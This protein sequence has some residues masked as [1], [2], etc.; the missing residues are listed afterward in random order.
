MI[1]SRAAGSAA[2]LALSIAGAGLLT[3]AV[4]AAEPDAPRDD[5]SRPLPSLEGEELAG[6]ALGR[7]QFRTIRLSGARADGSGGLGPVFNRT[8][9]SGCHVRNGRGRPPAS[10]AAPLTTM[11]IRLGPGS[12][13]GRQLNDKAVSGVEPEGRAVFLPNPVVHVE[14]DGVAWPLPSARVAIRKPAL[15][16]PAPP[17]ELSPRVAPHVAG[18]G[19]LERIPEAALAALVDPHDRDG[20]GISGRRGGDGNGRLG[21]RAELPGVEAQV[22]RALHEDMGVTSSLQ[23]SAN[24]AVGHDACAV[25]AGDGIEIS[26]VAFQALVAYVRNLAPPAPRVSPAADAGSEVFDAIGCTACH[27][28]EWELEGTPC[29]VIRPYTDLL[30]HDLGPGLADRRVD[31]SLGNREWRTAPLWG[32]GRIFAV[33]GHRRLLHDGRARGFVEAILWHGG[34][35]APARD[36]FRALEAADRAALL[37]FLASL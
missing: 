35:A 23:P 33:N 36:R 21:W 25:Q 17:V 11:V 14:L 20:D 29:R 27:T 3:G 6:F 37:A 8:S 7:A 2:R 13:Y 28:A 15:G 24:C 30:L 12:Q 10:D 19:L 4:A 34:E 22:A 31:G 16:P 5:F 26:D 18:T 1:G 32:A 9:C